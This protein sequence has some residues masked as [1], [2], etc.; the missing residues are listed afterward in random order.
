M[1]DISLRESSGKKITGLKNLEKTDSFNQKKN[2]VKDILSMDGT[3]SNVL[4][5]VESGGIYKCNVID[6][7]HQPFEVT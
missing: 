6:G 3:Q 1:F 7:S 2:A 5:S 4:V